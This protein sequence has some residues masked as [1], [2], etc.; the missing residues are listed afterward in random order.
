MDALRRASAVLFYALGAFILVAI[1]LVQRGLFASSLTLL[2]NILDL[3][4]ILVALIFGG[5]TLLSSLKRDSS[6]SPVAL[7][8]VFL[9]LLLAFAFFLYLNFGMM[10][11][12]A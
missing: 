3:P 7:T 8:I 11:A 2:L 6:P 12:T 4:L 10:F 9:P 1:V 5:S